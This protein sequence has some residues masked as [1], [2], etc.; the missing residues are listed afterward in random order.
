MITSGQARSVLVPLVTVHSCIRQDELIN[1][2]AQAGMDLPWE[3]P[4]GTTCNAIIGMLTRRYMYESGATAEQMASIVMSMRKWAALDPNSIIF[5]KKVPSVEEILA[6]PMVAD[7]LHKRECNVLADGAAMVL[8]SADLAPKVTK[9]PVYKL[10]EGAVFFTACPVL[11]DNSM[12]MRGAC[13][14]GGK[15]AFGGGPYK[16]RHRPLELLP[17]L[18]GGPSPDDGSHGAL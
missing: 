18:S 5:T 11:R 16:R 7:P 9:T 6:S 10:G 17:G 1:F 4:F 8:T 14:V 3:Y 13:R 15:G 12:M 2:F